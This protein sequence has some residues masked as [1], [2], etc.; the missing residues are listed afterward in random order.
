MI[1]RSMRSRSLLRLEPLEPRE[2]PATLVNASTL[3]FQ[4]ADGDAVRVTLS[5]AILTAGNV[6]TVFSFDTGS[7]D[8][9]NTTRQQLR[10]IDLTSLG[11]GAT[12]VGITT[13]AA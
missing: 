7:V 9:S 6:N 13:A 4:D 3:T 2:V 5:K 11:A 8:G 12:G 10:A 1:R